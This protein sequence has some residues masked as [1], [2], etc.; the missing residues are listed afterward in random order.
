MLFATIRVVIDVLALLGFGCLTAGVI[1]LFTRERRALTAT[2]L[3]TSAVTLAALFAI[4]RTIVI[5]PE[6]QQYIAETD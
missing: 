3:A 4:D 1:A 6:F 2:L 5:T